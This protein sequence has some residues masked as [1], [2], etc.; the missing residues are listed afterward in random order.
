MVA[1]C[2]LP[3]QTDRIGGWMH[4]GLLAVAL[5]PPGL[6]QGLNCNPC[7]SGKKS[8]SLRPT[9]CAIST[10]RAPRGQLLTRLQSE[11]C[12]R[13]YDGASV[14]SILPARLIMSRSKG[15]PP[16]FAFKEW[17]SI[18]AERKAVIP[19]GFLA[20]LGGRKANSK[21]VPESPK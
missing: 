21:R 2:Q 16:P 12:P 9:R 18:C 15:H 4:I 13:K 3:R 10:L 20:S 6:N 14:F 17:G 19:N 7:P 8:A 5:P 1:N 11:R